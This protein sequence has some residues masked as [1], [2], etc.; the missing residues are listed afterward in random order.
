[1]KNKKLVYVGNNRPIRD[2]ALKVTGQLQYT[3]DMKFPHMLYA[4]MLFSPVAHA[5]IKKIDTSKAE[6]LPGVKAVVTY[7]NSPRIPYNSSMRFYEHKIPETEYLFDDTV[8]FVGDRVAAVA[9]ESLEI[10]EKAI[11]L[12][13]VEYE[14]LP[15]VFDPEEA[16][17]EGAPEI[18]PG[19]NKV[20]EIKTEAGNVEE[21]L[22]QA[23]YVFEDRITVPAIHHCAIETHVAIATYDSRG[24]LTVYSPNQN[25][26]AFRIIISKVLEMPMSKVRVVRPAIGG[27]FGGKLEAVIEPVVALLAKMT[28][29]PVKMELNRRESIVSTRTRHAGVF[30]IKSGVNKD[31]TLVAQDFRV[32]LNTGAY[33]TSA[34]NVSGAMSHKV[35]KVYKT[36]HM[37]FTATPVYTNT[38]IAGAMR[39]YGSP[40]AFAAQQIHLNRVAK[41]LNMDF[42]DF[43]LKNLVEPDGVDPRFNSPHGNPR[44]LDCVT[45][46]AE[47]FNWASRPKTEEQGRFKR[48]I[49]MAI[50]SHGNGCF[51]A[52]RD[53]T[54]MVLKMNEDGT[55]TLFTGTHDMGNGTVT[56]E[57]QVI[58]EILGIDPE[59]IECI[60]ADTEAT[61][62]N[63]G[64][65]ASRG[66]FVSCN[67]AKKV[68]ESVRREILKEAAQLLEVP[69]EEL[70]LVGGYAVSTKD[71]EK[72]AT[73][74]DVIVHGQRVNQREIIGAET[75]ASPAGVTSYGAHFAEVEVDT[76]TGKVK[77][78]DYVAVHD[79]GKA[80][81]PMYVEGQIEGAVQMGIGYALTEGL[82]LDEKGK[83]TNNSFKKYHMLKASEMPRM[84]VLLVEEGEEP[85]PFGAKSI[86]ECSTVPSAP[87]V[88][89]A[90]SNALGIDFKD[91]PLKPER[92]LKAIQ[93]QK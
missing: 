30:Y 42:V 77:V 2:A 25:T 81:N 35:F 20:A 24:K 12:I 29:R 89:N 23:D 26:F 21:A 22:A 11:R 9:A 38:P 49:G 82:E 27:A 44:L 56:A 18:H 84:Q 65:Y 34:L 50:G 48:G 58:G 64:D 80:I 41:A 3:A 70:D 36:K 76:E 31:G 90:V 16:L 13:E 86:G 83:V 8:R 67:A 68:A 61:P 72:K 14:E 54:A 78:L 57:T 60:E 63:L 37:R 74:C 4:K 39:G 79:V 69:V 91:L 7:K 73:L 46:G 52:H 92:I 5:K 32:I 87:A 55:A 28:G 53:V 66:V 43:Q 19:G 6:A 33:A 40:Q 62:W 10:A 59:N 85:G 88:V 93:V 1:M 45:K 17:K 47:A 15:A 75:F 51:G 71:P